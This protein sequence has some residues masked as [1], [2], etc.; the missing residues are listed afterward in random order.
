VSETYHLDH[1]QVSCGDHSIPTASVRLTGPNG[2]VM[3]DAALGDGP[4]DAVYRAIN[5]IV[6]VPNQLIEFSVES[7][8]EGIDAMGDVTIRI[9]SGDKIYTGRGAATDIVVAS[10]KAYM[11]ALNRLL[12]A[13]QQEQSS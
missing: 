10:A 5:R 4:V 13:T 8:T 1:I 3:A 2:E 6:K 7:I 11:N 9:R 12:A